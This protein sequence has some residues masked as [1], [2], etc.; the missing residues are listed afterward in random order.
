MR[1]VA[2]KVFGAFFPKMGVYWTCYSFFKTDDI[3][4]RSFE[5]LKRTLANSGLPKKL[6]CR[7]KDKKRLLNNS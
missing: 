1:D 4:Q 3:Y 2:K 6:T 7:Y 5:N